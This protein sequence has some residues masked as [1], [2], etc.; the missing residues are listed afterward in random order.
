M[1]SKV[2]ADRQQEVANMEDRINGVSNVF[3]QDMALQKDAISQLQEQ[4]TMMAQNQQTLL[5]KLGVGAT[6]NGNGS[7]PVQGQVVEPAPEPVP[8]Y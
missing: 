7:A 3:E 1:E 4:I 8:A 2:A 6:P 5:E